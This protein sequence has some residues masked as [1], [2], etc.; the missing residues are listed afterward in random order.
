MLKEAAYRPLLTRAPCA[1]LMVSNS[2]VFGENAVGVL[3]E[4]GELAG[5]VDFQE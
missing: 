1:A 4:P 3:E 5:K 2:T